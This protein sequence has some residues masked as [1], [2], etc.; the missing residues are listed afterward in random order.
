VF[1]TVVGPNLRL[2]DNLIQLAVIV[3]GTLACAGGGAFYARSTGSDPAGGAVLGGFAGVVLSF[4]LSGF[5]LGL[6]RMVLAL[7]GR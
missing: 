7:R 1:D 3:A 5:V 4:L 2:R 6:V